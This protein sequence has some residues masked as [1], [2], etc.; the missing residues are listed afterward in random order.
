MDFL[1][2]I[3]KWNSDAL[4]T[5]EPFSSAATYLPVVAND[6]AEINVILCNDD[7]LVYP[8]SGDKMTTTPH[9][10][11]ATACR[12][13]A[14]TEKRAQS[15]NSGLPNDLHWW[16]CFSKTLRISSEHYS[17]LHEH[18]NGCTGSVI[19]LLTAIVNT[20]APPDPTHTHASMQMSCDGPLRVRCGAIYICNG[21]L[22]QD[23]NTKLIFEREH[24]SHECLYA[25][26][27]AA[28][29]HTTVHYQY[30]FP[31]GSA[32]CS[33]RRWRACLACA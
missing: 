27:Y 32:L 19:P 13:C 9:L 28:I 12:K 14:L 8:E 20:A 33:E 24:H 6:S 1:L 23:K 18:V 29:S 21:S 3:H 7:I 11:P 17:Y 5:C 10:S 30:H 4:Y 22:K 15:P 16:I 25:S 31:F 26:T 2:E